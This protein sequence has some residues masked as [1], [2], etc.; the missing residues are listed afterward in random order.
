MEHWPLAE[1]DFEAIRI[2]AEDQQRMKEEMEQ[3][4]QHW[5]QLD[6]ETE[7][8]DELERRFRLSQDQDVDAPLRREDSWASS[9]FEDQ[10]EL[11]RQF[12]LNQAQEPDAQAC[13]E[14]SWTSPDQLDQPKSKSRLSVRIVGG[15]EDKRKDVDQSAEPL[16]PTASQKGATGRLKKEA[17]PLP[18]PQKKEAKKRT[19]YD[20]AQ[21]LIKHEPFAIVGNAI[22]WYNHTFYELLTKEQALRLIVERQRPI[23]KDAGNGNFVEQVFKFLQ[24]EPLICHDDLVPSPDILI[25]LDGVLSLKTGVFSQHTPDIFAISCLK[26]RACL[27]KRES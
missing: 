12:R 7:D 9:D 24:L 1:D 14:D 19:P 5:E 16:V 10:D 18:S 2:E 13:R 6:A 25:F 8:Q 17:L 15:E 22:Y 27:K 21:D 11:D 3:E 23:V 20:V 26:A 4:R